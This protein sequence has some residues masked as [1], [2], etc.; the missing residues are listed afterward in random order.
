MNELGGCLEVYQV[1][2]SFFPPLFFGLKTPNYDLVA[3]PS[4]S[5]K[6]RNLEGR[7]SWLQD[8][9]WAPTV[10]SAEQVFTPVASTAQW[11]RLG[12]DT[13]ND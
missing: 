3:A 11:K 10:G 13:V 4:D 2:D 1:V 9:H 8:T 12:G 6:G 7:G 5:S